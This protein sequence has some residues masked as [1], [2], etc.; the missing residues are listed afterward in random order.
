[1]AEAAANTP[2]IIA[3]CAPITEPAPAAKKVFTD[4]VALG[5]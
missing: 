4:E 5:R 3:T 1:L 2:R